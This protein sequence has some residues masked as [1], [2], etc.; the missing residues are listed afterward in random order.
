MGGIEDGDCHIPRVSHA[1]WM[2][3]FAAYFIGVPILLSKTIMRKFRRE[4]GTARFVILAALLM[5]MLTFPIKM[6]LLWTVGL[7][8]V[9][10]MPEFLL[11]F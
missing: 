7:R 1:V 11:S 4:M 10:S 9:V 2:F 3:L 6:L 5:L 8:A